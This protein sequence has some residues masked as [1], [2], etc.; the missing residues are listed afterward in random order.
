VDWSEHRRI[1]DAARPHNWHLRV[2]GYDLHTQNMG[3]WGMVDLEGR[4]VLPYQYAEMSAVHGFLG[5]REDQ[6]TPLLPAGRRQDWMWAAVRLPSDPV[7]DSAGRKVLDVVEAWS[8]RQVNSKGIK[9]LAGTLKWGYFVACHDLPIHCLS[10]G[11]EAKYDAEIKSGESLA[12]QANANVGLMRATQAAPGE[13]RWSHIDISYTP[14][15]ATPACCA[16]TGLWGFIGALGQVVIEPQF[17]EASSFHSRL[18]Y[19]RVLSSPEMLETPEVAA[20]GLIGV[21]T[22]DL[23][24]TELK[25]LKL[26]TK[27]LPFRWVLA[28]QWQQV[29][30]EYDG[31]FTVQDHNGN[32]GMVNPNGKAVTPFDISNA[33]LNDYFKWD[34]PNA[35]ST[36]RAQHIRYNDAHSFCREQFKK[37][38]QTRVSACLDK[39]AQTDSR[40]MGAMAGL[41]YSS[42][43]A[44]DYG[45]LGRA[46]VRV[47][48]KEE[49][50]IQQTVYGQTN[51]NGMDV[52][53]NVILLA[54]TELVWNP[55]HRNYAGLVDISTHAVL[56]L[57]DHND[58][59][60]HVAWES[61]QLK[62]VR[63]T[64][65][66]LGEEDSADLSG[67]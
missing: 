28:P 60:I 16:R 30:D 10:A 43:G 61:L 41:M 31:H 44:Y 40:G 64:D 55:A 45:A 53:K 42:Y 22:L 63:P 4:F 46:N 49:T 32:W 20:H 19:V 67:S 59:S 1:G 9:A 6:H 36:E 18:S 13:M 8:G 51:N 38:Q 50:I 35:W 56:S 34:E 3:L 2:V 57:P 12:S 58:G 29:V 27:N 47:Q 62:I 7:T 39:I 11:A 37:L 25:E 24:R 48:L 26:E 21:I 54:G 66:T 52:V 15:P 33:I 17:L 65:S 5:A 14:N 23:T